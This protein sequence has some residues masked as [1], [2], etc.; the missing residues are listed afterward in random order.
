MKTRRLAPCALTVLSVISLL[1]AA[2]AC[3]IPRPTPTVTP[4][5]PQP[6]RVLQRTPERGQEQDIQA[7]IAITFDQA[8]D[9]ASVESAFSVS[10]QIAGT[11]KW[12]DDTLLFSPAGTGFSRATTYHVS[13]STTAQSAAGLSLPQALDFDFH[14]VGY[15]EVAAVQPENSTADVALDA[16]ITVMFNRPVVPMSAISTQAGLPQ[17][18]TF[19]PPVTCEGE[20]L[21]TS[22]YTLQATDGFVPGTTYKARVAAGLE[23]TT[24][25]VLATDYTWEFT[26]ERP[27]VIQ[28]T[29]A[30]HAPYVGPSP[31]ISV[32]F[33]MPM[34]H[35]SV[36]QSFSLTPEASVELLPGRF[37]WEGQT[38]AFIPSARLELDTAHTIA[39][40]TGARAR[41]GGAG[42]AQDFASGF[43]T[44]QPPRIVHTDPMDGQRYAFPFTSLDITFNSPMN[45]DSVLP[46]LTIL[47][48]PTDIY[49]SWMES[50]TEL[51]LSFGAQ[52]STA[53]TFTFGADTEGRYGHKLGE[54]HSI[55]FSTRALPPSVY[56]AS[57]RIGTFNA[58]TT[59]AAYVRHTNVSALDL[60]LYHLDT[61]SFLLLTGRDSYSVWNKFEPGHQNLIRKWRVSVKSDLN[62][63]LATSLPLAEDRVSPLRPGFY[64]LE[65]TAPDV[66]DVQRQ[67]LVVSHSA[68]TL[69]VTQDEALVWVTDLESGRPVPGLPVTV[70]DPFGRP[71]V[72]GRTD[73]NGLFFAE[74][75]L[76]QEY[77]PWA[78]I[79]AIAGAE[80]A[81]AVAS[82]AWSTGISH[83][84]F[85][86]PGEPH[87]S[88]YQVYLYTDRAIYRPGQSVYF[89]GI[90]RHDDDGHYTL[91]DGI[92]SLYI[93]V[94]DG[95]GNDIYHTDLPLS[96]LGTVHGELKLADDAG[97]GYYYLNTAVGER[98]FGAGFR[99]AEYRKPEF[100]ITVSTDKDEYVQGEE[101][102]ASASAKYY[103]GG[104][105]ADAAVTWR[106]M[107]QDYRFQWTGKP[108][109]DFHD[110]D[111]ASRGEQTFYGE[112]VA[113]GEGKTDAEG[114]FHFTVP[115]DIAA[116]KSSQLFTL[117]ASVT[118]ISHR[119]VSG[120]QSAVVH[121]GLFYIGL[122]P[123]EYIGSVD[124]ESKVDV[125]TVDSKSVQVPYIPLEVVFLRQ[126]WYNVQQQADDGRF[127]WEWQLQETP[128]H[129]TTITTDAT[130]KAIALFTPDKGGAY[131]V[132]AFGR[133]RL[134][135]EIRSSTYLWISSR[136]YVAWRQENHDRIELITDK[137]SYK[138]GETARILIPSPFQGE[139]KALLTVER[140]HIYNHRLFTLVSNSEQIEIPILSEYTPNAYVSIVLVKGTDE[141]NPVPSHRV[142]YVNLNV[143]NEEKELTVRITPNQ[144]TAYGPADKAVFDVQATD[145]L[146]R[147]VKAELSLQLVDLSVLALT[148]STQNTMLEHFYRER[149]LG[150]RT[151]ATLA[152]SVDRYRYQTQPPSA[153]GGDGDL[154]SSGLIRKRFLDTAY[155]NAKVRT[156]AQGRARVTV[157]LPDNLTT[158]RVTG[159]GITADTLVGEGEVDIVTSKDL[160]LRS[161]APRF[162][163]LGDQVQLG[164]VVHNNTDQALTVDVSLEGQGV[165][166]EGPPQQAV[167]PAQG[168][169]DVYWQARVTD[170]GSAVLTWRASSTAL[171]DALELTLP[172]YHYSTPE[173]VATAGQVP[174][175]E[176]RVEAVR[177]P[178]RLDPS[179]GELTI[180]LEPSLAAGM[181]DGLEYLKQ[182]PY[183]CIEQTVSRFLPNV[184]TYRA[185]RQMDIQDK[186]LETQ[187]PQSVSIGLQRLYALQHYDGGW[188]WW[189]ADDSNPFISAY[190]LLGMNAAAEAGFAVDHKV[191]ARAARYLHGKLDSAS[192]TALSPN[193][194]A[195]VLYVLAE[196]G[197]GDLGRTVALFEKRDSLDNYGK[198]YLIMALHTLEPDIEMGLRTL[199]SEL[200]SAAILSATGAHW[201][202]DTID[203]WTMNTNNR[204]TAIVL[205][206]LLRIDP[207]NLLIPNVVRWLMS[208]RK[209]GHWETTQETAWS[210]MALTDFLLSTGEL[211]AD[212]D[213]EVTLNDVNLDRRTVTAQDVVEMRRL[214]VAVQDLLL[215]ESNRIVLQRPAPGPDQTGEGQLY[216][217]VYLRY[218]LP[219]QDV[220]ALHRGIFVSRQYSLANDPERAIDTAQVGDVIQVKL[221]IIAPNDLHYLVVEDPLPA[222][223]EALDTSLKTTSA[224]YQGPELTRQDDRPPYWWYFCESELHDEKV[225]LFATYLG[226][227]TYEYTYLIR[228]SLAGRFL[229]MPAQ[230]YEMYFPEIFGRSDGGLFT[231]N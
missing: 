108:Y 134:E 78:P 155:W 62:T 119:E 109:Y 56:L 185:L 150:V 4:L 152:I 77:D 37:H 97:L 220:V 125:I 87:P 210:L 96:D 26:T 38:M 168:K 85:G 113:T 200:T 201:E 222:G 106:L 10:P 13:V 205:A 219:V 123:Q 24:G 202:E 53:Y 9:R 140:G 122:A 94:Q 31:T 204:S 130:G 170:S 148:G 126:T 55:H 193:T 61:D 49:T 182:Y 175:G 156:D 227:G 117:E 195:F 212:Y 74:D 149:G 124:H 76:M 189:L 188:G 7:P 191:M 86:I 112:L 138:P 5:P 208:T 147:G 118:D 174:S 207:D 196:Y 44:V 81:P 172:I 71:V 230:A 59:T 107:S 145:Y 21:N 215:E 217:S 45:R 218:Y 160:L 69:K 135:N 115:A 216:Y 79:V 35:A 164:A 47:P 231:I 142:G 165:E 114:Q 177:L 68:V 2:L 199:L 139:A 161:V 133:D 198:A 163:V 131:R 51:F 121:K 91:P 23:D 65:V 223:C 225:A 179:Q 42:M 127:Y 28:V 154:L 116:R 6:P 80:D 180:Q 143:S 8:M 54:S 83:W 132:R 66:D 18:V 46:N 3:D 95:Q 211:Q 206:A 93:T 64:C 144:T 157:D 70:F 27:R 57:D 60:A 128:V 167:V 20:W 173:V 101:I 141:N 63:H 110:D 151:G 36:E 33:N 17:P 187:L 190:A 25:G 99:V 1:L 52:P 186:E 92:K 100:E 169:E 111:Y 84:E 105:V 22:I 183:D 178:E 67:V 29:P 48:E 90:L 89:R 137:K 192:E 88:P 136:D 209:E 171:S 213:Y 30:D 16:R 224:A 40:A 158:W 104:P 103:F 43:T 162:F 82:T 184:M 159:K 34:D 181:R 203:Y 214:V 14:T 73:R 102:A 39:V 58:Y 75:I 228:A 153:K 226:K 98:T 166:I 11:F 129:T 12:Q 32:T 72:S 229:T 50:D 176:T 221:T 194:R 15:L 19:I 120:R 197:D 146:D 41:V